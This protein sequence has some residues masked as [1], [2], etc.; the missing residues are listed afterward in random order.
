[1]TKQE[2]IIELKGI[3]K[4]EE[5]FVTKCF[6]EAYK[7]EIEALDIAIKELEK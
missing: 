2:A 1:M 5:S 3:K 6:G 4:S 7:S